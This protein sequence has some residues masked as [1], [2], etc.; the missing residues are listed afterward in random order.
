MSSSPYLVKPGTICKLSKI[1]TD[2]TG[3]WQDKATATSAMVGLRDRIDELQVRLYAERKQ[4]LLV[5]LQATDTGG[6][7]G[8]IKSVFE[9]VNAQG[10]RVHSFKQPSELELEHDFLWRVHS[11]TPGKGMISVFNRSHY[12]DVLVVRAHGLVPKAVWSKRYAAINDFERNLTQNGTRILKFFLHISKDEQKERLQARLDDPTKTWKF[13]SGDLED[14]ARWDD[15]QIAFGDAIS[16]CSTKEAPWYIIP[17][18]RK[19]ARNVAIASVIVD[20]LEAMNPQFP[21]PEAGLDS[22]VIP[23]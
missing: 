20:T 8:T 7:D 21:E 15:Y 12:E 13:N 23:D 2:D 16:K 4:S 3:E 14:R 6:K 5:V 17:S 22:I 18:N 11:A 1:D 9:G 19:W 10:V